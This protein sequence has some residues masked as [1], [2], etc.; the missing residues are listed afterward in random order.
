MSLQ[1]SRNATGSDR[2][3]R[4]AEGREAAEFLTTF[5]VQGVLNERG[6]Y[7]VKLHD[8]NTKNVHLEPE[9]A[10]LRPDG[11]VLSAGGCSSGGGGKK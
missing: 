4:L 9:P 3:Q 5:V 2:E 8:T 10:S 11:D 1:S 6:N 7:A